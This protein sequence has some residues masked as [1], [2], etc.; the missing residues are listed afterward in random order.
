M[1]FQYKNPDSPL[2]NPAMLIRN[3][4]F[5][6]ING[7]FYDKNR[8]AAEDLPDRCVQPGKNDENCFLEMMNFGFK[9]INFVFNM[10]NSALGNRGAPAALPLPRQD[11]AWCIDD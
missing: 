9:I 8:D 4:D 2:K 11:W 1:H 6:L 5:L 7:S 10:I 3:L